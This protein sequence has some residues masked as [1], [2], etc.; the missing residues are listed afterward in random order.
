MGQ[1]CD[2]VECQKGSTPFALGHVWP[3]WMAAYPS[4]V[5]SVLAVPTLPRDTVPSRSGACS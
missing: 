1:C 3:R 4:V 2:F 5:A